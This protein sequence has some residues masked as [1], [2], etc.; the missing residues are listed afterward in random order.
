MI[1]IDF[2]V[3]R[4]NLISSS[5]PTPGTCPP[6]HTLTSSMASDNKCFTKAS[7]ASSNLVEGVRM[8]KSPQKKDDKT[9]TL[10]RWFSEWFNIIFMVMK[11]DPLWHW[12]SVCMLNFVPV[13]HWLKQAVKLDKHLADPRYPQGMKTLSFLTHRPATDPHRPDLLRE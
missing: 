3:V 9:S 12:V 2:Y 8:N 11:V 7:A 4:D 6:P 13:P 5:H 1:S 10:C